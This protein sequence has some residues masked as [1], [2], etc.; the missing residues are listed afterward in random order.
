MS[1][2]PGKTSGGDPAA[3]G[4][5]LA[6][7]S[8]DDAPRDRIVQA[9]LELMA[10]YGYNGMSLQ[11]VADRVG[12]HKSTLFHYFKGKEAL[13]QEAFYGVCQRLLGSVEA[14]LDDPEPSVDQLVVLVDEVMDQFSR[15]RFAARFLMRFL[16]S[17]PGEAFRIPADPPGHPLTVLLTKLGG[18]L[19][20][21]RNR[22]VIRPIKV[23][24]TLL[25]VMAVVLFYPA[26]AHEVEAIVGDD[27]WSETAQAHRRRELHA[28]IVGALRPL[29]SD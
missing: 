7:T 26:V 17:D 21:A 2:S 10:E 19:D 15:D 20:R 29:S 5:D 27:P 11:N 6:A 12:L 1:A 13:A 25:N 4:A 22:G 23:R 8:G 9:A 24:Q 14:L 16:I 18:W 3:A 28:F